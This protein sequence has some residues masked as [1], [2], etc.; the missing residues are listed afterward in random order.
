MLKYLARLAVSFAILIFSTGAH[1]SCSCQCIN[2]QVQPACTSSFDI[3]PICTL[4]TC[5][6]GPSLTPPP[7]GSRSSSCGQVQSCDT[8]G[9]CVWKYACH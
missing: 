5:P 2:G 1:A 8:Y 3:P 9:H 4:R 6:F 7:I